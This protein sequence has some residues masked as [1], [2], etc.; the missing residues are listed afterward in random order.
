MPSQPL[1]GGLSMLNFSNSTNTWGVQMIGRKDG[2]KAV[3]KM[4]E[5]YLYKQMD[6][7]DQDKTLQ[8][9]HH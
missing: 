8:A 5:G 6:V 4:S 1:P 9:K 7:Y 3:N 2:E